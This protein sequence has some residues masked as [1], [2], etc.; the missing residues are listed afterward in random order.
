MRYIIE[1]TNVIDPGVDSAEWEKANLGKVDV[2]EWK[3]F[4]PIPETTFKVLKG[5]EGM[6][7]LMHTNEKN[8]RAECKVGTEAIHTDSCMEFFIKPDPW[9]L[10]YLNFETNPKGVMKIGIGTHRGDRILLDDD[11][12][13]FSIVSIPEDGNWTL[14]FY[15][16]D[17]FINSHF[18]KPNPVFK[19]N[20]YKCA[21][22]SDHS[23]FGTW[24][25]VEVPNPDYHLT[26]FFGTFEI[27]K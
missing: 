26:D 23:H 22:G 12:S 1:R 20:V 19:G 4:S 16:P 5:P 9:D 8:L 24:N 14:K 7:V 18:K 13:K 3:G 11:R 15:I 2:E 10:R 21:E 6:S 27:K 25:R 17:E